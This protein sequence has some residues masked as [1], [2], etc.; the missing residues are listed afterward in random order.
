MWMLMTS[1]IPQITR[2]EL[3]RVLIVG[4]HLHRWQGKG[5][6]DIT[7]VIREQG[8]VQLDP[9]NPAGRYHDLFFSSRI[10]DYRRGQF[11]SLVYSEKVVFE[12]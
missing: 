7:K 1:K 2:D 8:L 5:R 6:N 12:T 4:C 10:P 11:E 3:K 9:L